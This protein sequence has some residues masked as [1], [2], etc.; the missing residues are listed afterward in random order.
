MRIVM[1]CLSLL[2]ISSVSHGA[3]TPVISL[4]ARDAQ[5]HG[6]LKYDARY[7]KLC[8]WSD[9]SDYVTWKTSAASGGKFTAEVKYSCHPSQSGSEFVLLYNNQKLKSTT[10]GTA[11]WDTPMVFPMG[12]LQ[13]VPGPAEFKLKVSK[14]PARYV[15]DFYSITIRPVNPQP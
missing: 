15:M 9:P 14:K 6:S 13:L 10:I 11:K 1:V 7:D 8:F 2:L 4:S 3:E 12:D 5:L